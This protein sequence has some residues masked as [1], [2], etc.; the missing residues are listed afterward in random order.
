MS[1]ICPFNVSK[2]IKEK[3]LKDAHFQPP[4]SPGLVIAIAAPLQVPHTYKRNLL[5]VIVLTYSY[6]THLEHIHHTCLHL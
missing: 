5:D 4:T 6:I 3:Q 2:I 1:S